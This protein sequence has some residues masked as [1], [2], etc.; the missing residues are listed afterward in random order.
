MHM[1]AVCA[2]MVLCIWCALVRVA[3]AG[4]LVIIGDSQENETRQR[5]V[6]HA[7]LEKNPV[8]VFRVGDQV[9]DGNSAAQWSTFNRV[10]AELLKTVPY[11]PAL[12]NHEYRASLYFENFPQL[13]NQR[14]YAVQAEGVYCIV[15]DSNDNITKGSAQYAWLVS[16]LQRV[17][18]SASYIVVLMH[19]PLYSVGF[20]GNDKKV[21]RE[22]LLPLFEK[23]GVVAVFA[24]HD[25]DY[26]RLFDKGIYFIVTGGG[27]SI[28]REK[29]MESPYLQVY[30]LVYHFCVL[31]PGE[32]GLD[33][34]VYDV[35]LKIIDQF[36]IPASV[37]HAGGLK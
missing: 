11:Y 14:W 1:R 2:G 23:Y 33:V 24:G 32:R 16:E 21:M 19:H 18:K 10:N 31:T 5:Q 34:T 8:A 25:H 17:P 30:K 36:E 20:H 3:C 4:S 22:L 28:L 26:Q 13:H 15:L 35:N 12:G 27:G 6:V 29:V 9:D 37:T 7:V